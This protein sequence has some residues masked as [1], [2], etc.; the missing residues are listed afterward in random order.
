M[1]ANC[2]L[3]FTMAHVDHLTTHYYVFLMM[4]EPPVGAELYKKA[5]SGIILKRNFLKN[6]LIIS[7]LF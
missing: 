1:L 6:Y 3:V 2:H 4:L 5:Y 7:D